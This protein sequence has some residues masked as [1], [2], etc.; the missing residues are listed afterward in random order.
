MEINGTNLKMIRGDSE[1]ISVSMQD[2]E[3]V[4]IPLI[5][6]DTV[7]FTV[8]KSVHREEITLQKIIEEFQEGTAVIP[9]APS[10]TKKLEFRTYVYDIQLTRADGTVKTIIPPSDFTIGEEVTYD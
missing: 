4:P 9:I 2:E 7:Y 3:G 10:D 5:D 1:C 6:G 8:K